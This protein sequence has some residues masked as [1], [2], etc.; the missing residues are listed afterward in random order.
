L[1]PPFYFDIQEVDV[2]DYVKA[3]KAEGR[4]L[5]FSWPS[6]VMHCLEHYTGDTVFWMGEG[7]TDD[8][9]PWADEWLE[10]HRIEIPSWFGVHDDFLVYKR[11]LHTGILETKMLEKSQD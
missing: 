2:I 11:K 5:F 4:A 10:V 7:S 8:I 3:G 1:Q 6:K 9:M